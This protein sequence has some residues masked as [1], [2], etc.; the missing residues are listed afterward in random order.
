[1][2][3]YPLMIKLDG[4]RCLIV[5][6]GQVAER[7]IKGLLQTGAEILVVC[8]QCT[9][10]IREWAEQGKL[11]LVLRA[12]R[13]EDV[14]DAMVIIA[15]TDKPEINLQVYR[16][17]SACP[18]VNI[19]DRP[20]LCTF[21]VPSTV[22]RGDI[23]IAISTGGNY[24][25]LS[26]KLRKQ[27]EQWIGPEYEAYITFLGEMR[28]KILALGFKSQDKRALLK[29]MLD[30]RFLTWTKERQL[31]RRNSEAEKLIREAVIRSEQSQLKK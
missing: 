9:E 10:R 18:L 3:S 13:E 23:Q 16:A 8:I 31:E 26:M 5:G 6:G 11:H 7:K 29:Q 14:Q 22:E 4:K 30:D 19:V 1:M 17:A 28:K 2:K 21:T 20:D 27:F 12:F 24:P 15:A 25:G